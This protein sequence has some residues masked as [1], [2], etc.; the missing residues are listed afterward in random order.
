MDLL[1]RLRCL[2]G[3]DLNQTELLNAVM[4]NL[5]AAPSSP[6]IGQVYFDTTLNKYGVWSGTAWIYLSDAW[7]SGISASAPFRVSTS[8]GVATLMLIQSEIDHLNLANKGTNTHAQ[9]DTHI[10]DASKHFL[11]SSL[12]HPGIF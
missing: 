12:G 9:I 11:F 5:A 3:A 4:Q 8:G 2:S 1:S 6:R 7:L 10:A